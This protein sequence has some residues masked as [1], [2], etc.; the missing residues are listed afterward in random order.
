MQGRALKTNW[1]RE[2]HRAP[3][4]TPLARVHACLAHSLSNRRSR[5]S[6]MVRPRIASNS[7]S[8]HHPCR[9]FRTCRNRTREASWRDRRRCDL[10]RCDRSASL[11]NAHSPP[12][13]RRG[14][15]WLAFRSSGI[16]KRSHSP[17]NAQWPSASVC[18]HR[19]TAATVAPWTRGGAR[20]EWPMAA[21]P[22]PG[23]SG[24]RRGGRL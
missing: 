1:K 22:A 14:R 3:L 15:R 4:G 5:W 24:L 20:Y 12:E 10:P 16:S 18:V 9:R 23:E 6:C 13:G 7:A 2:M 21:S 17:P 11:K 19:R 8:K